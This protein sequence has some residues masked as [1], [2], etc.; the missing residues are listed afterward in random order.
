MVIIGFS[1]RH[2]INVSS[3]YHIFICNSFHAMPVMES[4]VRY[5]VSDSP[6]MHGHQGEGLYKYKGVVAHG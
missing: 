6:L 2:R 1:K 4:I 3:A 5:R